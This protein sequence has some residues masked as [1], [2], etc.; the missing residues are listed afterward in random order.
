MDLAEPQP[1]VHLGSQATVGGSLS[2]QASQRR[3]ASL[4]PC[5]ANRAAAALQ[6]LG[7]SDLLE[8]AGRQ[9]AW[10]G[11]LRARSA[12]GLVMATAYRAISPA[13]I[14]PRR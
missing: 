14:W 5:V 11:H 8:V 9:L 13:G 3:I 12:V 7:Q 6:G 10:P 1:L 4:L 2:G